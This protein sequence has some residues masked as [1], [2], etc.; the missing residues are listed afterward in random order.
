M[1][2]TT[3][4]LRIQTLSLS[5]GTISVT[6]NITMA[7]ATQNALTFTGAGVL[8]IGGDFLPGTG[9]F[10][11]STGTVNYN[12]AAQSVAGLT[13]NNLTVSGGNTKTLAGAVSVGGTLNLTLGVLRL[14]ANNLTLTN[15]TAISG[16]P[17][18]ASKM[19]ETDG[20]G[21]FIRSANAINPL[22]SLTYPVGS[23]G[24]YNPLII[25]A[26]PAGGAAAR[27]VS[28]R[29]V[30]ANLGIL[31]NSINKY[32]DITTSGITTDASTVLSFQYNAGE[33]VGSS[34]LFQPYTNTSGT[35]AVATGPS[36]PGTNPATS[37]GSASITGFWTVGSPDTFYSYQSGFWDQAST[38]TFDP[39][40]T[41]GPGTL[42]PG[43]ND[44]VVI[45]TGRT[46]SLQANNITTNLDITI[47][48]GGILDQ[49]TFSFVTLAALRGNGVLKLSSAGFPT[50]TINTFVSTDGGTTEYNNNGSMSAT[51]ATYYHLIV[52]SSGTVIQVSDITLNGNLDVKQ[53]TFQI[54]D[55]TNNRRLKLIIRGN[56]TVDNSCSIRV[57]TGS[58]NSQVSPL[59]ITGSFTPP[60]SDYYELQ[61]H[62]V[63]INGDFTNNGIVRFSNLTNP[64]YDQLS[65]TGMATVYF[66]GLSD[67]SLNCNGQTDFY[68]LV[69]DKGNDQT[70]KLTVNSSAYSNFRLFGANTSAGDITGPGNS[71]G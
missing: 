59:G 50:A 61:S 40:G 21:R 56:V 29:A 42:V 47:N 26:L 64:V 39:G 36:F 20:T 15:T 7:T 49:S 30:P 44:K 68:N 38:W 17:F 55:A 12:G 37:T 41:T 25:S 33:I 6:G 24:Y 69:V 23:N 10:T 5:T 19:I 13:Y 22:F 11:P 3:D 45:L 62:R 48:N 16:A 52:R 9:S 46:V 18:S 71:S 34:L 51:Q 27:S 60:F 57:G 1:V 70:F 43:P 28:I 67:K 58:T 66:Q 14:G 31:T 4:N 8:N 65:S 2:T 53:G 32:W 63:Q 35:W 54:N